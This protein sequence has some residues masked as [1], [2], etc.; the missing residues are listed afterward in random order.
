MELER[1]RG[2]AHGYGIEPGAFDQN[3]LGRKGNFRLGATHDAADA[4]RARAIAVRDHAYARVKDALDAVEGSEFFTRLGAAD[5]DAV[6]ANEV[7]I[8]GVERVA[9]LEHHVIG[10]VDNVAD[11]RGA[12][13][14]KT[15]F[16]PR[17]R[18]FDL[19]ATNDASGET[20]AE[21]AGD[22]QHAET[23][24][25]VRTDLGVDDRALR[26]MLDAGNI[27]AG[28]RQPRGDFF[29]RSRGV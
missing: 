24:R 10:D 6:I 20:A 19:Q 11:A 26:P 18:R 15:L 28:K 25:A 17:G 22:T 1:T 23:V 12:S 8:E 5:D 9:K 16:E 7:V 29:G 21:L 27:G 3:V 14:F 2:A 4:D 13:G